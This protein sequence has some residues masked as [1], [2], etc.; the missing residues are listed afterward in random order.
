[1]NGKASETER[2]P[3]PRSATS[4]AGK[5]VACDLLPGLRIGEFQ[6]LEELKG[7]PS[8]AGAERAVWLALG[9]D[10]VR[11]V[12]LKL[13]R[14]GH[15]DREQ[16]LLQEYEWLVALAHDQ[17]PKVY[18]SGADTS[19][20][21]CWI[22]I[23][24]VE[25]ATLDRALKGL[26]V[27]AV[28]DLFWQ[29]CCALDFLHV[30]HQVVHGDVK[31]Q[32]MI[33]EN[34]PGRA[35]LNLIDLGLSGRL[36]E[37]EAGMVRGTPHYA[38][39]SVLRG[40]RPSVASDLYALGVSFIEALGGERERRS[41]A[42]GLVSP[43]LDRVLYRLALQDE[44]TRY[45]TAREVMRD[46]RE[47]V[48]P[49]ALREESA[50]LRPGFVGRS[51][52]LL[53]TDGWLTE[54]RDGNAKTSAVLVGGEE[55]I[56]KTRFLE[57]VCRRA[58][59]EK[60]RILRQ[61]SHR[62]T[63]GAYS[64]LISSLDALSVCEKSEEELSSLLDIRERLKSAGESERFEGMG[65]LRDAALWLEVIRLLRR[66][67]SKRSLLIV[68]DD[69]GQESSLLLEFVGFALRNTS[70][71]RV[72]FLLASSEWSSLIIEKE[73]R[74]FWKVELDRLSL[75]ESRQLIGTILG[76][77]TWG[78]KYCEQIAVATVGHPQFC[79][80]AAVAVLSE[81]QKSRPD[82][83]S[84]IYDRLPT[85]LA[86]AFEVQ[87]EA[88]T[89]VEREV[90]NRLS[91]VDRSAVPE[92]ERALTRDVPNRE[93]VLRSLV[94][95]GILVRSNPPISELGTRHNRLEFSSEAL[96][97]HAYHSLDPA[98]RVELHRR[99]F[100]AWSMVE[101]Q[102]DRDVAL[103]RHALASESTERVLERAQEALEHLVVTRTFRDA[104]QLGGRILAAVGDTASPAE[105][106]TIHAPLGDA[107]VRLGDLHK[108][109]EAFGVA[110]EFETD[111]VG[112]SRVLRKRA[113]VLDSLGK[114]DQASSD[115]LRAYGQDEREDPRGRIAICKFLGMVEYRRGNSME[116]EDWLW[117]AFDGV[118]NPETDDRVAAIWNNLGAI[119][120]YRGRPIEAGRYYNRAL[121]THERIGD[122]DGESRTLI[123][124]GALAMISGR[125]KE[126]RDFFSRS[127][128]IKR[129]F[130]YRS[131]IA[132]TLSNLA[133]L[134]H[135]EGSF[136]ASIRNYEEAL[137]I[138]IEVDDV[139]GEVTTRAHLSE[140]WRLKGE[141][142]EALEQANRAIEKSAG[143][144]D[145]ARVNALYA[146][147]CIELKLGREVAAMR[148]AEEGLKL[149]RSCEAAADEALL[150]ALVGEARSI[151]DPNP[152]KPRD[153]F[154]EA[155]KL[156]RQ[157]QNPRVLGSVLQTR[158][159]C[160]L[161][162]GKFGNAE[163]AAIEAEAIAQ[164]LDLR[165]MI[166][167]AEL[168]MGQVVSARGE[169]NEASRRLHRAEEY[170]L[171]FAAPE[172]TWRV[173]LALG[174]FHKREGR[175][176]RA[177]QW[178]QKGL[179]V[180][181]ST[182]ESLCSDELAKTY[183]E[184]PDRVASLADMEAWLSE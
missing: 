115:L 30:G 55:G 130:G 86:S 58:S 160:S 161:V 16:G 118:S 107:H 35:K 25:G 41:G 174:E 166:A 184:R 2:C 53:W 32:N 48:S 10:G 168:V 28:S 167:R 34:S 92:I 39:A 116:A 133:Q 42:E 137:E 100:R 173:Y 9:G 136:R 96:R 148:A 82:I 124:L 159:E 175:D 183:L 143:R 83:P 26:E 117:R 141:L 134:D 164:E 5:Q 93:Q 123:G 13:A 75:S 171:L 79:V 66:A 49:S 103:T 135:W 178:L 62:H 180:L 120:N 87:L 51:A 112:L 152:N 67:A 131:A 44:D 46:L 150:M 15:E 113:Y 17:L 22:A 29:A 149:A 56:G 114:T 105:L 157:T 81:S 3:R 132:L 155:E 126:A 179:S 78:E 33:V 172:F 19:T 94:Q 1:M 12:V 59:R 69:V 72:G 71:T 125:L 169:L 97:S 108:A 45:S 47:Q 151:F 84:V 163:I 77:E 68:F 60:M 129:R 111:G 61:S 27:S 21:W 106:A 165:F 142:A 109:R 156:A 20:L 101:P 31:P 145:I 70:R 24:Y 52:E 14:M 95:I 7:A 102:G 110:L 18:S 139:V 64:H 170:A 181:Q 6:L 147:G 4:E 140:V 91:V 89:A 11:R 74:G 119:A 38:A 8:G 73:L 90:V 54:L 99:A 88:L 153:Y 63:E 138:R 98:R 36:G 104:V 121:R 43:D 85:T 40:E 144:Q 80:S 154:N 23:Q 158:A 146:S 162:S 57:E 76:A 177:F 37:G 127:L 122:L 182:V 176:Q 65:E 50:Y 128:S